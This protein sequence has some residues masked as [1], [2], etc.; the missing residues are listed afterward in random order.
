MVHKYVERDRA[1]VLSQETLCSVL[2]W[3]VVTEKST[4]G[5][6]RAQYT[7]AVASWANKFFIKRAIE[8]VFGVE[9]DSVNTLCSKGKTRRFRGRPGVR[10]D[11]KKAII[12]LKAGQLLDLEKGG[13]A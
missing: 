9:V 7:F 6:Q 8:T 12:S 11:V 10:S 13:V 4:M 5:Q 2:R 3:P 1:K